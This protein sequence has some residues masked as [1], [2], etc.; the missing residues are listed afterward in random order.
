MAQRFLADPAKYA[1]GYP[2]IGK[3]SEEFNHA[4]PV[5]IDSNG[6]LIVA[7]NGVKLMGYYVDDN[8]TM[9]SDNQT[10]AKIRPNYIYPD[11]VELVITG[12]QDAT[13]T[14]IGAYAD[15]SG[16]TGAIAINLAASGN[17]QF[18]VIGFDPTESGDDDD[19]VVT[20]AESQR[21]GFAQD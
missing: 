7:T 18:L 12:D 2:V 5:N 11:G 21:D 8:E 20:C 16:T 4:D 10:V 1:L 13:Q 9:A 3:N 6:F 19:V 15:L 17:G 14:D